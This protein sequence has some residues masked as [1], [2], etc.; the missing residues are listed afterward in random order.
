MRRWGSLTIAVLV[1]LAAA[2]CSS[3]SS[4]GSGAG[5]DSFDPAAAAKKLR[6]QGAVQTSG[7]GSYGDQRGP[8]AGKIGYDPY[9]YR[10][11]VAISTGQ[12]LAEASVV[13]RGDTVWVERTAITTVDRQVPLGIGTLMLRGGSEPPYLKLPDIKQPFGS[14][15]ADVFEP[16]ALLDRVAKTGASFSAAGSSDVGG[17]PRKRFHATLKVRDAQQIGIRS[18]TVWVDAQGVPV[19][20]AAPTAAQGKVEYGIEKLASAPSV[21]APA[22]ST[23]AAFDRP[24]PDATGPYVE[25]LTT[26]AGTTPIRIL[27][28]PG[29]DDWTCWKVESQPP[30]QGLNDTRPS[31]GTCAPPVSLDG[32]PED[33]YAIPLGT[34]AAMPYTLLGF[35]V[36]P[37]SS[38]QFYRFGADPVTVVADQSGLAAYA[39]PVDTPPGLVVITTPDAKLVCGPPGIDNMTDFTDQSGKNA[40]SSVLGKPWN[41]LAQDDANALAG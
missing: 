10:I 14:Y 2:G 20:L 23:I 38:V 7:H 27:R 35:V 17:T 19:Q 25:V 36:P 12:Q 9:R 26:T 22:A 1:L 31:G 39:G 11:R 5:P 33:E 6:A 16:A 34:T 24:L 8:I 32:I 30:F 18:L 3:G 13:R 4:S 21:K 15:L 41:C 40:A 28:A 37:T 29:T